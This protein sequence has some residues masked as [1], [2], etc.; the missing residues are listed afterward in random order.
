MITRYQIVVPSGEVVDTLNSKDEVEFY[1]Q[2]IR[3]Q[4][5]HFQFEVVPIQVS[6]VKSGFGR[7]PDLH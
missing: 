3:E 2:H 1:T 5:P 6:N 4:D 7:D